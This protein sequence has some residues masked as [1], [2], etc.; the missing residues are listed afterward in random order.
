MTDL[1]ETSASKH[2][3]RTIELKILRSF[4]A[5]TKSNDIRLIWNFPDI[6]RWARTRR[7]H[8]NSTD[9]GRLVKIA[10]EVGSNIGRSSGRP[11]NRWYESWTSKSHRRRLGLKIIIIPNGVYVFIR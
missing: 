2:I 11:R 8:V 1:I 7:D 5:K 10:K 3:L 4:T 6:A 9:D